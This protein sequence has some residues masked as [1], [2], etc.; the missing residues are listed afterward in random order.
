MVVYVYE[1]RQSAAL[2]LAP[3]AKDWDWLEAV[4][5]PLDEDFVRATQEAQPQRENPSVDFFQ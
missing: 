3:V 1:R 4:Q 5:G 2:V